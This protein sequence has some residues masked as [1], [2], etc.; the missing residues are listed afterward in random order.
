VSHL[1]RIASILLFAAS[2]DGGADDSGAPASFTA[3][4]FNTGTSEQ[5]G[6]DDPPDDGYTSAEAAIS[7]AWYG[8]GLAWTPAVEATRAF[9]DAV[10]ADVVAFQEIFWSEACAEIPDEAHAGFVCETWAPGDPTVAQTVLGDDWQVMCHPGNPDKC[11]AIRTSFGRFRG[12]ED[13]FCLE[14]L[15]GIRLDG[16][17]RGARVGRG[18][19]D[20]EDGGTLTLVSV[21]GSSG[22]TTEDQQCRVRQVEQ[23]FVDLGD[24]EPGADGARN[25]VMGDLNTDPGR[26]GSFDPSAARWTDF[27]GDGLPFWFVTEV[28]PEAPASYQGLATIDHE[29][30]DTFTGGCWIAG[31]TDG[32]PAVIDAV[33]F[34]HMPVVCELSEPR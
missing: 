30:S 11:A 15:D 6:H 20:L 27:A 19:I 3:V 32:H 8:D 25:L 24:G 1:L 14:G 16:C 13:A 26:W 22:F 33:Y 7:D 34:D 23:V 10:D 17:G 4:T 2:C 9:F 5:M 29:I 18:V 28:G 31:L 21:H 12:C